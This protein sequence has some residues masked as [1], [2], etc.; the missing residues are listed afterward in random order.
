MVLLL[1]VPERKRVPQAILEQFERRLTERGLKYQVAVVDYN[2]LN[3][4]E[5]GDGDNE[6]NPAA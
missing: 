6:T 3:V 1:L 2:D 5:V 4:T